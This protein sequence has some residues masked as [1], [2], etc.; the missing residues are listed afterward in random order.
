MYLAILKPQN[1]CLTCVYGIQTI[2]NA[3]YNLRIRTLSYIQLPTHVGGPIQCLEEKIKS[4]L[5]SRITFA[6]QL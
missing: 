2:G 3:Y 6:S 4:S 5:S 1:N